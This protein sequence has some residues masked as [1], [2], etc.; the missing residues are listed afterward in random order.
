MPH[1]EHAKKFSWPLPKWSVIGSA[2]IEE[3]TQIF[4]KRNRILLSMW[5]LP[6]R[7]LA[8]KKKSRFFCRKPR[9]PL[10]CERSHW[11]HVLPS[12]FNSPCSTKLSLTQSFLPIFSWHCL[13]IAQSRFLMS[14]SAMSRF[15]MSRSMMSRFAMS[16]S[17][18]SRSAMSRSPILMSQFII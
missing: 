3:K 16:R 17:T 5:V 6:T 7:V 4:Q 13:S 15:A 9:F 14:Q 1:L 11:T 18:M 12:S 2:F 8:P 10:Q